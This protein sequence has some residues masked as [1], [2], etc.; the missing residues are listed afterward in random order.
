MTPGPNNIMLMTSGLNFGY[1]KSLPHVFGVMLGF[2]FM[3]VL[4]GLGIGIIFD[5]YPYVFN[6]LN[7]VGIT[8]LMW[9][10][11]KIASA[12]T[13]PDD[14]VNVKRPFT[15]IQIV[16]FQWLNPKAWVMSITATT[17]FINIDENVFYQVLTIAFVYLLTGFISTHTWVFGG[18]FLKKLIK[19]EKALKGFNITMALL[20]VLSIVPAI[21]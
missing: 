8:Y 12:S 9:M 19:N 20:I 16:I 14:D 3:V 4:I 2:S 17:T 5:N 15:F 1:K 10:A 11:Y 18:V 21:L 6:I 13:S 7:I